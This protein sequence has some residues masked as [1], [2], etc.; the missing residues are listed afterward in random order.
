MKTCFPFAIGHHRLTTLL[1]FGKIPFHCG[2]S[3]SINIVAKYTGEIWIWGPLE[4]LSQ[5]SIQPTTFRQRHCELTVLHALW[6]F[7]GKRRW[8]AAPLTLAA[9]CVRRRTL[10]LLALQAVAYLLPLVPLVWQLPVL[11]WHWHLVGLFHF[12]EHRRGRAVLYGPAI[13]E[14]SKT[15]RVWGK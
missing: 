8:K 6:V 12:E 10:R 7:V 4:P 13:T 3:M 14:H 2:Y 15:F 5:R 11:R 9:P 1:A